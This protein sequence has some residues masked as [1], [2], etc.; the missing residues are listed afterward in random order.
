MIL[1]I[2]SLLLSLVLLSCIVA[3]IREL[4]NIHIFTLAFNLIPLQIARL[5]A[6]MAIDVNNYNDIREKLTFPS[7]VSLR[8]TSVTSNA[9]SILYYEKMKINND[10][11]C[12]DLK[13][14]GLD[15][16]I[17]LVLENTRELNRVPSTK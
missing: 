3:P 5:P 9:S 12:Y 4:V 6:N 8:S 1:Y 10:L 14:L 2:N 11:L 7:K 16:R 15:K 13:S 17:T